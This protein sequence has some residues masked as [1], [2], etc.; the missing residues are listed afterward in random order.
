MQAMLQAKQICD[1]CND[2]RPS[3]LEGMVPGSGVASNGKCTIWDYLLVRLVE[4]SRVL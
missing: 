2:R 1:C 3:E 4:V